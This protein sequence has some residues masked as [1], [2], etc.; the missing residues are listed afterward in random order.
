MDLQ[1][2]IFAVK[3]C[4]LEKTYGRL[5]SRLHLFQGK[6]LE[7]IRLERERL[8]DEYCENTLLLDETAR[9]SRS[10]IMARLAELQRDYCQGTEALL[11]LA[12]DSGS[13]VSLPSQDY[14]EMMTLY[15]EFAIDFATQSMRYALIAALRAMELQMQA[16]KNKKEGA[17]DKYE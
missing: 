2:G 9:S 8:Q 16:D 3:L 17:F 14:A 4:D 15:A 5:Q 6:D 13:A 12:E 11:R 10:P 7:Q 1:Y